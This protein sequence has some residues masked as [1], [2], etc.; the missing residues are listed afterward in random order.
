[1]K[2]LGRNDETCRRLSRSNCHLDV[3]I[4]ERLC[5]ERTHKIRFEYCL[6]QKW[7]NQIFEIHF[8]R[9]RIHEHCGERTIFRDQISNCA[10]NLGITN[11][12]FREQTHLCRKEESETTAELDLFWKCWSYGSSA[13]TEPR[14]E[15]THWKG[16]QN[17]ESSSA[18]V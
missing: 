9:C 11:L 15:M 13:V 16:W 17:A 3:R 2:I 1:M 14:S 12:L 7:S 8:S 4:M 10:G 6:D 5:D 18:G